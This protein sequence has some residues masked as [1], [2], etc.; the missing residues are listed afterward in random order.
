MRDSDINYNNTPTVLLSL[1]QQLGGEILA[2]ENTRKLILNSE[3]VSGQIRSVELQ[4]GIITLD[5]DVTVLEDIKIQIDPIESQTLHF[6]YC[7]RGGCI[8]QFGTSE[9]QILIE[10]FQS[11]IAHDYKDMQSNILVKAGKQLTINVISVYQEMYFQNTENQ[12]NLFAKKLQKLVS[13]IDTEP[14]HLHLGN[15]NLKIAEQ[16]KLLYRVEHDT[17]ITALLSQIGRYYIILANHIDQFF[18]EIDNPMNTSGLLKKELKKITELSDYISANPEIQHSIKTLSM[19]SGLSA[20]KLQEGFKFMFDR[21]VSD[22]IRNI[23]LERA[24]M[25]I[26]TTELNISEV[27]YSIGLTSRSYFCKIF[28]NKYNCS[29]KQYKSNF[30]KNLKLSE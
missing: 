10:E 22:F 27:V 18:L 4:T 11:G 14:N 23:R 6:I 16:I 19:D 30:Q 20:S 17:E 29:P 12:S 9:K 21:T 25:L 2:E 15:Y 13:Y 5:I 3:T 7:L 24:E 26:K 1:Q 28:K 8:H